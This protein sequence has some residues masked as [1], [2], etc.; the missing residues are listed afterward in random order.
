MNISPRIEKVCYVSLS[1]FFFLFAA[2]NNKFP[3]LRQS[4]FIF[5]NDLLRSLHHKQLTFYGIFAIHASWKFSLWLLVIT[6]SI[7]LSVILYL[8]FKY[9]STG[10]FLTRYLLFCFFVSFFMSASLTS[11][12]VSSSVFISISLLSFSLLTLPSIQ[13]RRDYLLVTALFFI[14]TLMNLPLLLIESCTLLILLLLT[15]AFKWKQGQSVFQKNQS[16]LYVILIANAISWCVIYTFD[17]ANIY[18]FWRG[19]PLRSELNEFSGKSFRG[20]LLFLFNGPVLSGLAPLTVKSQTMDFLYK[21]FNWETRE[22]LLS[23][24]HQHWLSLR[25]LNYSVTGSAIAS[26]FPILYA[27]YIKSYRI[28]QSFSLLLFFLLLLLLVSLLTSRVAPDLL[29]SIIWLLPL[30]CFLHIT[31]FFNPKNQ[32]LC[33]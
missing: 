8:V 14:S 11:S 33:F 27:V 29:S 1:A 19:L 12:S 24:Q 25:F 9:F 5:K 18:K 3:L 31:D 20:R 26:T 32:P 6:Q 16:S 30:P 4:T 10:K 28:V 21:C 7:S 2:F 22:Y 23:R 15:T 17:H 13:N